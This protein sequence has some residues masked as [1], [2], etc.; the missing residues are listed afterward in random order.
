MQ[1]LILCLF[2][3]IGSY[4]GAEVHGGVLEKYPNQVFVGTGIRNCINIARAFNANFIEV[5]SLEEDPVL[6]EHSKH[7]VPLFFKDAEI[8]KTELTKIEQGDPSTDLAKLI[9][10]IH[11]PITFLLS[12]YIP[13]PDEQDKANTI[14]QELEQIK[15]HP[16]NTHTIMIEN[17]HLAG[18]PLFGNIT[19]TAIVN[20]LLE[21]N[22]NYHFSYEEGGHLEREKDAILVAYLP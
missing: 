6:F 20:K 10:D 11:Q 4:L 3:F 22:C 17:I 9:C 7:I 12:S 5:Y 1:V 13:Y 21:I 19:K 2:L 16:I 15:N 8:R 14:L 18:T